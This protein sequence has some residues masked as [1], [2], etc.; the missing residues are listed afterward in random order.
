MQWYDSPHQRLQLEA[1][2]G[3]ASMVLGPLPPDVLG[4]LRWDTIR[5]PRRVM[6]PAQLLDG[7]VFHRLADAGALDLALGSESGDGR[8]P[9][10]VLTEGGSLAGSLLDIAHRGFLF[11]SLAAP[12]D[13]RRAIQEALAANYSADEVSRRCTRDGVVDGLVGLLRD[14][15]L[16]EAT[17]CR[18]LRRAW[19]FWLTAEDEGRLTTIPQRL[20]PD[21]SSY[22]AAEGFDRL[23][24]LTSAGRSAAE[25]VVSPATLDPNNGQRRRSLAWRELS[26]TL[27]A[28]DLAQLSD[29]ET[30]RKAFD[31][32]YYRAIAITHGVG[33]SSED[34]EPL[35]GVRRRAALAYRDPSRTIVLPHEYKHLLGRLTRRQWH[36][37]LDACRDDLHAWHADSDIQGLQNVGERLSHVG[38]VDARVPAS[39]SSRS[40]TAIVSTIG[41]AAG[42]LATASPLGTLAG[43]GIGLATWLLSGPAPEYTAEW[44]ARR[45]TRYDVVEVPESQ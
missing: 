37:F 17:E 41:G 21:D 9:F 7:S 29:A 19:R 15:N 10:E 16:V 36:D 24:L 1:R 26:T 12:Y 34:T 6:T 45:R 40:V 42:T 44:N 33:L 18:R 22:F 23:P 35:R 20:I 32:C 11:T 2:G 28:S 25:R 5:A 4:Q 3:I 27:D 38:G 8:Y 43:G 14:T 13:Q 30:I 31:R 39:L